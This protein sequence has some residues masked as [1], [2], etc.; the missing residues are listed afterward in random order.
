VSA[1]LLLTTLA[2]LA[3]PNFPGNLA[4]DLSMPCEPPCT[5]CHAGSP[6]SGTAT[7]AFA[8]AMKDRGLVVGDATSLADALAAMETD[9]VDSDGDG[10]LDVDELAA[11]TDPN[12]GGADLCG[13]VTPQYGCFDHSSGVWAPAGAVTLAALLVRRRRPRR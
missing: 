13:T 8:M 7:T 9:A 1:I 6:A 3:V 11:G 12:P 5:V 2:A 10:I 4:S